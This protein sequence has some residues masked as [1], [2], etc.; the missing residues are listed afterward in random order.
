MSRTAQPLVLLAVLGAALS[1]AGAYGFEHIGGF[2]PCELCLLQRWPH[3]VAIALGALWLIRPLALWLWGGALSMLT[4]AVLG[5]YHAGVQQHWWPGP[6]SC[7]GTPDM[8]SLTPDQLMARIMA[9]PVVRCDEVSAAIFGIPMP[10]WS[11]AACAALAAI[12]A[13]A[14]F[15]PALPG[16][17]LARLRGDAADFHT[18]AQ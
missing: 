12:W 17:I 10:V 16:R 4:G 9:A 14:L 2:A 11:A 8:G 15:R 13:L 3:W 6:S 5:V 18:K 7:S 1:L